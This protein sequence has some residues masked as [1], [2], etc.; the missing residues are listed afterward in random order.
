MIKVFDDEYR[1]GDLAIKIVKVTFFGIPIYISKKTSTA[2][3]IVA[4]LTQTKKQNKVKG[5]YETK[6]KSKKA[7][8]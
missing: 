1:E 3:N 4:A 8:S 6:N 5:F 2:S 7:Q